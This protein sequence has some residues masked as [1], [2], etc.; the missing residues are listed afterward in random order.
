MMSALEEKRVATDVS[1]QRAFF[2][3]LTDI[4]DTTWR[5]FLPTLGGLGIGWW[6]GG[7]WA[8]FVGFLVGAGIT[9]LLIRQEF[10]KVRSHDK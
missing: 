1:R 9:F 8:G 2:V 4:A 3:L 7:I 10:T 6:I 5:M